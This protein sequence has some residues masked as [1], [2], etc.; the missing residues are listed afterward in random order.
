MAQVQG[1]TRR[2]HHVVGFTSSEAMSHFT[3]DTKKY[4]VTLEDIDFDYQY[5]E[6]KCTSEQLLTPDQMASLAL[7]GNVCYLVLNSID[8]VEDDF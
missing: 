7:A 5:A 3:E 1:Q 4:G 6:A 2:Y 8:P